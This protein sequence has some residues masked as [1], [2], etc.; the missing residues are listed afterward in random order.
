[1]AYTVYIGSIKTAK[2]NHFFESAVRL[3]P[4][5]M[6]Y[7]VDLD[8]NIESYCSIKGIKEIFNGICGS[9]VSQFCSQYAE[10]YLTGR[11]G[12]LIFCCCCADEGQLMLIYH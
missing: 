7:N 9:N 4:V 3:T 8:S 12:F 6:I 10:V 5:Y 2:V 1:M 11:K